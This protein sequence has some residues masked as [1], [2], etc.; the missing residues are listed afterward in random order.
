[1]KIPEVGNHYAAEWSEKILEDEQNMVNM[2]KPG[3]SKAITVQG[4][5]GINSMMDIMARPLKQCL[6]AIVE[7]NVMTKFPEVN[8]KLKRKMFCC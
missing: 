2:G 3:K 5:N 8:E 4:K 1:M 6:N 7:E